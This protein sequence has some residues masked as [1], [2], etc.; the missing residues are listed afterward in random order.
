MVAQ[1]PSTTLNSLRVEIHHFR[2]HVLV[3]NTVG[4]MAQEMLVIPMESAEHQGARG[5][6]KMARLPPHP[7]RGEGFHERPRIQENN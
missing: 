1:I 6:V 2:F 4:H 7:Q 3:W 5:L